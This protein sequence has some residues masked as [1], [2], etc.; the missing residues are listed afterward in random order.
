MLATRVL[1]VHDADSD[2]DDVHSFNQRYLNY[3]TD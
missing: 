3:Q 2:Q 1:N